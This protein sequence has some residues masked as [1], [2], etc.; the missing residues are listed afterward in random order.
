KRKPHCMH[1]GK[2]LTDTDGNLVDP[3]GSA[4]CPDNPDGDHHETA[5]TDKSPATAESPPGGRAGEI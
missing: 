1:C 5:G 3:D 4:D 2:T